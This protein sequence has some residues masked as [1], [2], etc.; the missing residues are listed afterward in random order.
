MQDAISTS[1]NRD[2]MNGDAESRARWFSYEI[3]TMRKI[4]GSGGSE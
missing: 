4:I 2:V 3:P 1:Y